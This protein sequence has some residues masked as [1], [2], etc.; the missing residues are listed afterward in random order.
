MSFRPSELKATHHE[1][2]SWAGMAMVVESM[3]LLIFLIGSLAIIIQLF[4]KA[5]VRAKEGERLAEAVA[6]ATSAA[7]RFAS[8]PLTAEGTTTYDDLLVVC[9]VGENPTR[10]G[11][12]YQATI[13]VMA[14]DATEPV[15][16]LTTS[17]YLR[18]VQ[19]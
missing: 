10:T 11:T 3:L 4:A 15:Y 16:E 5:T 1:R 14:S 12:L 6:Y 9:E 2:P 19:Q 17:R 13:T 7:E 8:D 18:E